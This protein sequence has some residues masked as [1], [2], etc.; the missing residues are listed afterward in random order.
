MPVMEPGH[1]A[2]SPSS[3]DE[4]P[5]P[6]RAAVPAGSGA[7]NPG[8]P[9]AADVLA[10]VAAATG[11]WFPLRFAAERGVARD[12]LDE[13]LAE[14]RLAGLVLAAQWVRG[15]GQGY[16]LTAAGK[17][18]TADP[19]AVARLRQGLP[20]A[21][22]AVPAGAA[23][24]ETRE[25]PT[26]PASA[27]PALP[28][29]REPDLALRPPVVVPALLIANAVWF[30][31]CAVWG[32]R[33]GLTLTRSVSEGHPEVL[34]RFG[35][36]NGLDLMRGEWWRLITCCFV[37]VGALHLIGNLFALAMMGPLAEMLWGRGR[38]LLIYFISGLAGSALAM[39]IRPDALLAGASGAIWG[40][41]M[42]LFAWLFAFRKQ[43]PPDVASDWF[44]RLS[45]VF[46]L[47]AGVSFL[48]G[49]SWEGHLGGGVAGFV[50]AGLLN[51]ARFGARPRRLVACAL[52]ALLPVLSVAGVVG[53]M[54]AKGVPRWQK[55]RQAAEAEAESRDALA[56]LSLAQDELREYGTE[57]MPRLVRIA[58]PAG[59]P[60]RNALVRI[61][62]GELDALLVLR[63]G[64]TER[65]EPVRERL[66]ALQAT[67]EEV[68]R[69]TARD[70]SG[71]EW[72][73]WQRARVN[74]FAAAQ[75]EAYRRLLVLLDSDPPTGAWDAWRAARADADRLWEEANAK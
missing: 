20:V 10:W 34:H 46:L 17:A 48:P 5:V 38:L 23:L 49:V 55:L 19:A 64:P 68:A 53:A 35:A 73:D 75:A 24:A 56:R 33:W 15:V 69:L 71:V 28:D 9:S 22:A 47:N 29:G 52:L 27:A 37:H 70:P 44:R 63:R 60:P 65:A 18:V 41:Q 62:P 4:A 66:R 72:L 13:P 51:A 67:A 74:R 16:A 50:A 36:V 31:I 21:V 25:P 32:I 61:A 3:A 7:P 14:L 59:A 2:E 12:S 40:I 58:P 45:V 39:A 43:L 1:E 8:A 11:P 26:L 30:F 54:G 57:V 6:S 42:S